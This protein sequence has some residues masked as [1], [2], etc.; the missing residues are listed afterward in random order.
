MNTTAQLPM[1][2]DTRT[3]S[4]IRWPITTMGFQMHKGGRTKLLTVINSPCKA[5]FCLPSDGFISVDLS[6][7]CRF[8]GGLRV[9]THVFGE[10]RITFHAARWAVTRTYAVTGEWNH[11]ADFEIVGANVTR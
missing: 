9:C 8:F 2:A 1:D 7:D 3:R 11:A 6:K 4:E 10:I 5:F